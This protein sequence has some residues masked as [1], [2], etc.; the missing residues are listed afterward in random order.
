MNT[1]E[2]VD[3]YYV[4]PENGDDNNPG[5]FERPFKTIQ[6]SI[7]VA[8]AN[9]NDGNQ[10]FL[11]EGIYYP[12]RTIEI[13]RHS[14]SEDAFL[15]IQPLPGEAAIIDGSQISGNGN[16]IDIRN[17]RRVNIVGLEIRN[18]PSHG[19]EVVNGKYINLVDNLIYDT[20]SMGIRVRGAIPEYSEYEGGI[21]SQSSDIVIEGNQVYQTNLSNSG[22]NKG[23]DNWGGA[24]QAWNADNIIIV[25]NT[26]GENYGEGIGLS[27]VDD[28]IVAENYLY[29]NFS[30]QIY[31]DNTT[32]SLVES[33]FVY[34]SGDRQFYRDDLPANGIALANEIYD[35][36]EPERFYLDDNLIQRNIIVGA[37][38]GIIY[39]TWAGIHQDATNNFQGL[40]DTTIAHNTIYDAHSSSINLFEDPNTDDV[41]IDGNIFHQR[42]NSEVNSIDSLTG[43]NLGRNLWFGDA[44]VSRTNSEN[45]IADPLVVNP[46]GYRV[47]DYQLRANSAAIDVVAEDSSYWIR[48]DLGD[49]GAL[50]YGEPIFEAGEL[51]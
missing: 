21:T 24:I 32:D 4:D 51:I 16:I 6:Q 31:L 46:G 47:D 29:D 34:N 37:D 10:I 23:A 50:E 8:G 13:N 36:L 2:Y 11:K 1:S 40:N 45:I 48:D 42:V 3:A 39:G 15:T 27:I 19:I 17:V 44:P 38:S 35:V 33:N 9:K 5:T 22:R 25:R 28:A 41:Q 7:D 12:E 18:A 20:Q 14:G 30:A 43:V 49:L 26:V